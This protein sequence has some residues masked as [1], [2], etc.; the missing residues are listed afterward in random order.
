MNLIHLIAYI[1]VKY[2]LERHMK[3]P[4]SWYV[5]WVNNYL[6]TRFLEYATTNLSQRNPSFLPV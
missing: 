6:I 1:F 5:V 3:K 4:N 2:N